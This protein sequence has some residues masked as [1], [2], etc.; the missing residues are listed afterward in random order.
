MSDLGRMGQGDN[1]TASL[2]SNQRLRARRTLPL[3][4]FQVTC[5]MD[6]RAAVRLTM[7]RHEAKALQDRGC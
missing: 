7:E 4:Q 3:G 1:G 5:H 2:G 6:W